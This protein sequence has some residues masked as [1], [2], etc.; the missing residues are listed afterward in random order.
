MG[1]SQASYA[2]GSHTLKTRTKLTSD[3]V[4][5]CTSEGKRL[6]LACLTH[7]KSHTEDTDR[8]DVSHNH[9]VHVRRKEGNVSV[10]NAQEMA[11]LQV[12]G[13]ELRTR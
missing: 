2:A 6:M 4:T 1:F 10:F 13:P 11:L 12:I 8:T 9:H 3:T 5:T 7:M